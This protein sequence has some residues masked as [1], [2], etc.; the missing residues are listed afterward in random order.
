MDYYAS[1]KLL[2][3][4]EYLV[5]KGARS[6]AIP[7]KYGQDMKVLLSHSN[8]INWLSKEK[9]K[10]WFSARFTTDLKVIESTDK[11]IASSLI[12]LLDIIKN[13][14][15]DLFNQGRDFILN[16][17]FPLQWGFGTSSTLISLLAQWSKTN[18]YILLESTFGGSGYDVACATAKTPIV[19]QTTNKSAVEIGLSSEITSKLLFIYSGQKQKSKPEVMRFKEIDVE[20]DQI[21]EMNE[22][23]DSVTVCEEI[24]KFE[25]LI[26]QSEAL[27]SK[28]LTLEPI[29]NSIFNDYPYSLK[30]LGAWGGDFFMATYRNES[31]AKEYFSKRGYGIQF[32]YDQIIKR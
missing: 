2:L 30:S 22:L 1:G 16:T 7:L 17:D 28:V 8:E 20:S 31:N 5:L 23:V 11:Q 10:E 18:P 9:K 21:E 24:G 13:Q 27:L 25:L 15:P 19:F 4:G 26:N 32:T 6:L 3:F 14:K 29:K 12:R